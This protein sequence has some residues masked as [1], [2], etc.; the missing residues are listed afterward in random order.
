MG[1][2]TVGQTKQKTFEDANFWKLFF[3]SP[4]LETKKFYKENSLQ[5]NQ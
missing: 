2:L 1:F 3:F 5:I 4:F